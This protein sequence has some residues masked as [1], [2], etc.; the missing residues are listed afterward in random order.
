MQQSL[1]IA[2]DEGEPPSLAKGIFDG[3]EL[4]RSNQGE[5]AARVSDHDIL[6]P[7]L[8]GRLFLLDR[9]AFAR[10]LNDEANH[11]PDSPPLPAAD[12]CYVIGGRP[13]EHTDHTFRNV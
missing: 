7:R 5:K 12:V 2:V 3:L 6:L 4:A 10:L 13:G 11:I 9:V 8:W 1:S